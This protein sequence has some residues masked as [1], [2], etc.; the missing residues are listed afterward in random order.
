MPRQPRT[1]EPSTV[2]HLISRFV[3]RKRFIR[4]TAERELYLKHLGIALEDSDWRV[5]SYGVMSNHIH[6]AS[7]AGQQSL[8]A[9]IRRVHS[10]FAN[11]MNRAHDRI[12]VM[13]V[14]GP[15]AYPV[16]PNSLGSLLAY[17][18]NNPVRAGLCPTAADSAWTSHRAYVGAAAAPSWLHVSE[19]L[20]RAG[21]GDRRA[22]D[23]WVSDPARTGTDVDFTEERYESQIEL[24]RDSELVA[25][26]SAT[27]TTAEAI[28]DTT[29]GTLGLMP[30]QLRSK[31]RGEAE[32]LGRSIAVHC[33][34][35][36][37]L[38][39]QAIA[40]ALRLSQQRVSVLRRHPSCDEIRSFGARV[41]TRIERASGS[42]GA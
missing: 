41:L 40:R 38:S 35:E 18:H 31:R 30:H 6:L 28:V 25:R 23:T 19:G 42:S 24:A 33:A 14:R 39:G 34:M 15:K 27:R 9:W 17:I 32:R 2:Y 4:T 13:F 29:A 10:P 1:I 8:D 22:F 12:G 37:G 26:A 5:L 3:D 21:F 11:A 20:E 36:V 7:V 16:K